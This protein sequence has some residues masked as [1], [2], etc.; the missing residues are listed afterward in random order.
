MSLKED[1]RHRIDVAMGRK[2]ADLVLKNARV[3]CT[4]SE[5]ILETKVAIANE[6]IVA[7]GCDLEARETIDIQ[8]SYLAPSFIDA[9][10]HIE[11]SMLSPESFAQAVVP[12]GTGAVISDPHEIVNVLGMEGWKYMNE[13]AQRLPMDIYYTLPSCVPATCMETS[14]THF[15]WEDIARARE[16]YPNAPA[17][18]EMMNYP[19]VCF[20]QEDV[21]QKIDKSSE[22][23]LLCDG[24]APMLTGQMLQA[25]LNAPILTDHECVN[26]QE[27]EEK[28]RMG[29]F[30]L[31]REGSAARNLKNLVSVIKDSN[32]H[33]ICIAS[34][35]RHPEDLH[36]QGHLDYTLRLLLSL[37]I[38]FP[39]AIRLM[40]LNPALLYN[41]KGK[42]AIAPGYYADMVVLDSLAKPEVHSVYYHGKK[43]AEKGR[44]CQPVI[45]KSNSKD[46]TVH[47]P[48]NLR[49]ALSGF[50][51]QGKIHAIGIIPGE[52][53]T[54]HQTAEAQEV[55]K[56]DLAY[57]AVIERHGKNGNVGLGFVRG[58]GIQKGAIASSVAHDSHNLIVAGKSIEDMEKAAQA[59]ANTGGGFVVVEEQKPIAIVPLPLAGLMSYES[60]EKISHD[61]RELEKAAFSLGISIAAP[62]MVLSFLALPV[63]PHLKLTDRGLVDV[64]TFS[65]IPLII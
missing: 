63:I 8:G 25:Y 37:G 57:L 27:A 3:V 44:L 64:D 36:A 61:L 13:A 58:L 47:L 15:S 23:G 45:P 16:M 46:S 56:G 5:E 28:I 48:G 26:A 17:L 6:R 21:L 50:P 14:G 38:S 42:G 49:D 7:L 1:L 59:I 41:L 34:D 12:H 31:I 55:Q 20:C 2:P 33:R 65:L 62:F 35:D 43:V 24:H 19:G 51:K 30:L 60:V 39:R 53:V 54:E 40:T 9:H 11:S 29:M 10:I 18:S 22:M 52:L 4:F 32:V